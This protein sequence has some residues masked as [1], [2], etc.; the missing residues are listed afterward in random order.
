[1]T[2]SQV[3]NKLPLSCICPIYELFYA[4]EV[5]TA[6]EKYGIAI[7]IVL[8]FFKISTS[9]ALLSPFLSEQK[10]KLYETNEYFWRLNVKTSLLTSNKLSKQTEE[11][12][13][14]RGFGYLYLCTSLAAQEY[15]QGH[16]TSLLINCQR[17]HSTKSLRLQLPV[18]VELHKNTKR[19]GQHPRQTHQPLKLGQLATGHGAQLGPLHFAVNILIPHVVDDAPRP[20]HEEGAGP[21]QSQQPQA[22]QSARGRGHGNTPGAGPIQ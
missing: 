10:L 11:H 4:K 20:P 14:H 12:K 8:A 6:L 21:K 22:W 9:M 3:T 18:P 7:F 15:T 13:Q 2:H 5:I 16:Q 19:H 1:M 17:K